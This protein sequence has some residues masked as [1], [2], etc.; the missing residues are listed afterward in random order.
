M[1]EIEVLTDAG[2]WLREIETRETELMTWRRD[3]INIVKLY[4]KQVPDG[5][6]TRRKRFNILYSNTAT[7]EPA[8]YSQP[9]KV[10]VSRRWKDNRPVARTAAQVLERA[11]QYNADVTDFDATMECAV[12][13]RLLPGLGQSWVRYEPTFGPSEGEDAPTPVTDERA[14]MDYVYWQDFGWSRSR[15]WKEVWYVWRRVFMTRKEGVKKFG[16]AFKDVPLDYAGDPVEDQTEVGEQKRQRKSKATVYEVWCKR[17]G[18][19]LWLAKGY[20]DD[21]LKVEK[22]PLQLEEFWPCPEPML[23]IISTDTLVPVP[24]YQQY[25]DQAEDLDTLTARISLLTEACKV[26]GAYNSAFK[27]DLNKMVKGSENKMVPVDEWAMLAESGGIRGNME[28]FPL[29][30]IVGAIQVLNT[31]SERLK[32]Q[33]YELIGIS[34]IIRGASDPAETYGAQAIKAQWGSLRLRDKQ[35]D[36]QR[37]AR[38]TLAI[39]AEIIAEHFE[40]ETIIRMSGMNIPTQAQI[41]EAQAAVMFAQQTEQQPSK[42]IVEIAQSEVSL[43]AVIGLLKNDKMRGF[44]LDVE[45]DSTI[46]ADEQEAKTQAVEFIGALGTFLDQWG[47]R[48]QAA[49]V[50]LPLAQ[51]TLLYLVRQYKAGRQFE[52][53]IEETMEQL[54]QMMAQSQTKPPEPT[55]DAALKSQTDLQKTQ[56]QEQGDTVRK[57]MDIEADRIENEKDRAADLIKEQLDV[58]ASTA[59]VM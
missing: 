10:E 54:G 32:A 9:P 21:F 34:D 18:E 19:V 55:P 36:V 25:K 38:D 30:E 4:R 59:T 24:E 5:V 53:I 51:E 7:Q 42:D 41:M 49:P 45:T 27:F 31:E 48:V 46:E 47:P 35:K 17:D 12:K 43:E 3:G 57:Q 22:D 2:V 50:L 1:E 37:F 20:K 39:S 33:I 13:D 58:A 28:M 8:L 6:R 23:S 15:T 44:M 40:P 26:M 52:Q 29:A 56:M 11:A 14:P 16:K